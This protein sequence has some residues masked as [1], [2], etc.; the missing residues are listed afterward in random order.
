M[1]IR[2]LYSTNH[3]DIGILYL[4]LALFSGIIGTTLSMFIRLELGLPGEGLLNG[5][6]QLYNVIITGHG[7][8]MLLFMVMPALFGGFG[9][10]LVPILI[11][12]PDMAFPRLNNISFWLNP[13]ALGLLL[14]STMV[15]QGAGTGWTACYIQS[16]N[17]TRCEDLLLLSEITIHLNIVFSF[18]AGSRM[19]FITHKLT[20]KPFLN[21]A[22]VFVKIFHFCNNITIRQYAWAISIQKQNNISENMTSVFF[23]TKNSLGALLSSKVKVITS[24]RDIKSS[25]TNVA[26]QR[27]KVEQSFIEWLV[28]VTDGDGTFSFSKQK[29]SFGFTF[30]IGQSNYN[31]RMLYYIK[32]QIGYGSI[33]KDGPFNLQYQIRDT[34]TLLN[35]I[36][37]LFEKYSLHTVKQYRYQIFKE[38]L[39]T[40]DK[41]KRLQL[42]LNIRDIPKLN[43]ALTT[44]NPTKN[45]IIGFIE[46]EGSFYITKK[47]E[48]RYVHGFGITQKHDKHLLVVLKKIFGIKANIKKG[49]PKSNYW[50]LDTTN[51]RVIEHL[52]DYFKDQFKGVKSLEYRIW[53]RS[54]KKHKG[55]AKQ[56]IKIQELLNNLRNKHKINTT[57]NQP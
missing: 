51:S 30:K 46:A 8:I 36:I 6:G 44:K 40:Q 12:A 16:L 31:A 17:S 21:I 42:L 15:E 52:I 29:N 23:K 20:M 49:G 43:E 19:K 57:L 32:S 1:A 54:Y 53:A 22:D 24:I 4:L 14:L 39:S 41:E 9:N 35:V 5:N 11:G 28:G 50:L 10:W 38:A 48:G 34:Q 18:N 33:T 47:E 25:Y 37:P 55:N 3:K 27:L 2:W 13:S 7:I 26:H 56:L 45:W